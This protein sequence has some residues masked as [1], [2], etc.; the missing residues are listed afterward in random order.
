MS[1]LRTRK[2][3]L[4]GQSLLELAIVFV[5]FVF[6]IG[7]GMKLFSGLNLNMLHRIDAYQTSR[8]G[9]ANAQISLGTKFL[10]SDLTLRQAKVNGH[11]YTDKRKLS[12]PTSFL[13]Y[14]PD[15]SYDFGEGNGPGQDA[16]FSFKDPR[17][18]QA[19]MLL[20]KEEQIS[21]FILRY[22]SNQAYYYG[23]AMVWVDDGWGNGHWD[24]DNSKI[25]QNLMDDCIELSK[26]ALQC[27]QDA[28][29]QYELA[30]SDPV[31]PGPL[32]PYPEMIYEKYGIHDTDEDF[33]QEITDLKAEHSSNRQ[34]IRD[35]ADSMSSMLP[36]MILM[37]YGGGS[38]AATVFN[39][40]INKWQHNLDNPKIP[41][42]L[43]PHPEQHLALYGLTDKDVEQVAWLKADCAANRA[44][45]TARIADMIKLRDDI[46]SGSSEY[47][48][49]LMFDYIH[50]NIGSH[51]NHG[52]AVDKLKQLVDSFGKMQDTVTLSTSLCTGID[53]V[54]AFLNG[55]PANGR[56][57]GISKASVTSAKALA[58]TIKNS[59]DLVGLKNTRIK[60][61]LLNYVTAIETKLT[62]ALALPAADWN[63]S[64]YSSR[65]VS[66]LTTAQSTA[67][68][69]QTYK[70][71]LTIKDSD[72]SLLSLP[73][74]SIVSLINQMQ[75]KVL[76]NTELTSKDTIT[77]LQGIT[78]SLL[79]L[80]E[81]QLQE[82]LVSQLT[83]LS[84]DF[85]LA[86]LQNWE[87]WE[88]NKDEEDLATSKE[89]YQ[90]AKINIWALY[91]MRDVATYPK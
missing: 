79:D 73:S 16:S 14:F 39:T 22:K 37:F 71:I 5:C 86:S 60:T 51:S 70:N 65:L 44:N 2:T 67:V 32:D 72:S 36:G 20:Y 9:A 18:T 19:A 47:G 69:L 53:N 24:P 49:I 59:A 35:A 41:G 54:K 77:I 34:N 76:A 88:L 46:A 33:A 50:D 3:G 61:V 48:L 57:G 30:L 85:L 62:A 68:W 89:Y 74:A 28:I 91:R 17:L 31:I 8:V 43:D 55:N 75:A 29:A 52:K 26:L 78:A 84:A 12:D 66:M 80:V 13:E 27:F 7:A 11:E 42:P 87:S 15:A 38:D 25:V 64:H 58:A 21:S 81:V 10:S 1:G 56:W 4:R 83:E 23:N 6:I 63:V 40:V 90:Y 45:L 82:P